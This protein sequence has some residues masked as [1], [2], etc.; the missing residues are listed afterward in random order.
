M[1]RPGSAFLVIVALSGALGGCGTSDS[2]GLNELKGGVEIALRRGAVWSTLTVR[3]PHIIGAASSLRI[4]RG[5]MTG[6]IGGQAVNIRIE[7]DGAS[8]TGP[9]GVVAIDLEEDPDELEFSGTWS[10]ARVNF[11][12]TTDSFRGTIPIRSGRNSLATSTCNYMLDKVESNGARSGF[13]TCNG[14]PEETLVEIPPQ[15]QRWLTRSELAVVLLALLSAPPYT[16]MEP[17]QPLLQ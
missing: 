2:L 7:A 4:S 14:L 6:T 3:L 10:G 12:I 8:G 5:Q 15:I 17:R 13:S 1:I 9:G 16:N 11:K